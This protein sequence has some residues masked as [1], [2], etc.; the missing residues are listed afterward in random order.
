[1]TQ[2]NKA[3]FHAVRK[4]DSAALADLR[5]EGG[6]LSLAGE[7]FKGAQIIDCDLSGI[8]LTNTEWDEC[9]FD[10]VVFGDCNLE[11]AYFTGS[12]ILSTAFR[13]GSFEGGSLE[14]CVMKNCEID[15]INV[16]ATEFSDLQLSATAFRNL[17]LDEIEWRSVVM[18]EGRI[19]SVRGVSGTL[20]GMTL[21]QVELSAFETS[22]LTVENC[23]TTP[24]DVVPAGFV[25]REGRRR[26]I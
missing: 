12:M 23:T 3:L 1:M 4:G 5:A 21:R 14:G 15:A 16:V 11:G 22:A 24:V 9:S 8:D 18:N 17:E 25:A 19:E 10:R 20:A 13:G 26:R 2:T 7:T 6:A